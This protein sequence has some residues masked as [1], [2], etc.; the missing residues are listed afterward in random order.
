MDAVKGTSWSLFTARCAFGSSSQPTTLAG[1]AKF[2]INLL[3]EWTWLAWTLCSPVKSL[4]CR[5]MNCIL[6]FEVVSC[7]AGFRFGDSSQ[8]WGALVGGSRNG[9]NQIRRHCPRQTQPLRRQG[10]R[11]LGDWC[12]K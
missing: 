11:V 8:R 12:D 7:P 5:V 10:G 4:A 2:L 6:H 9:V 1:W 3:F